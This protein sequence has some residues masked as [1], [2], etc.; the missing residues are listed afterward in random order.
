MTRH[1]RQIFF[2]RLLD[3]RA[4]DA[5]RGDDDR[6]PVVPLSAI[7]AFAK[8]SWEAAEAEAIAEYLADQATE[9]SPIDP[10]A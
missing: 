7:D 8:A 1:E 5:V 9:P 4:G 6:T 10:A 2:D 3:L